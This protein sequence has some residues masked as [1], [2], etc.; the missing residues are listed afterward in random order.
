LGN[1]EKNMRNYT[2]LLLLTL[3]GITLSVP[4]AEAKKPTAPTLPTAPT[5]FLAATSLEIPGAVELSWHAV[6]GV[7]EYT[8]SASRET[9]ENWHDLGTT[10]A[11]SFQ[12]KELPEGTKYYF[13][14][15]S[16]A[17]SGQSSWSG[18]VVQYSSKTKDSRPALLLPT[19]FRVPKSGVITKSAAPGRKGELA[20]AWN[21]VAGARSYIVQI[22]ES[23]PCGG[24]RSD[25]GDDRKS[26]HD[27]GFRDLASVAGIEYLVT[28][29]LSG[30]EYSFRIMG[31][32]NKGQR[33]TVSE[34][35][36]NRA[37]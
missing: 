22:C 25:A 2:A 11:T 26:G 6:K 30:Q 32:D 35:Q 14:I 17:R 24:S 15:A 4:C 36:A 5:D 34:V 18:A 27:D 37:P 31:I 20:L 1:K 3:A 9:I 7:S 23:K 13:R 29:L 33:G 8:V 21:A 12:V 19:N 28:G 16:N 10:T